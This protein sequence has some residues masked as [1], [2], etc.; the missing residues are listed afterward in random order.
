MFSLS[1]GQGFFLISF[2]LLDKVLPWQYVGLTVAKVNSNCGKYLA[3]PFF[4]RVC[5]PW[6]TQL[7]QNLN[8]C[9]HSF[10]VSVMSFEEL[11]FLEDN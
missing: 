10:Y 1:L 6:Q 2:T 4:P 7:S 9:F 8:F 5:R 11:S 3:T